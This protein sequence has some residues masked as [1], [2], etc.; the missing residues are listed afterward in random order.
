MGV[1]A[2]CLQE[3]RDAAVWGVDAQFLLLPSEHLHMPPT[4][5]TLPKAQ[6]RGAHEGQLPQV[7]SK[8]DSG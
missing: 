4:S 8:V 1:G 6:G 3:P 2:R 7:L 5:Q